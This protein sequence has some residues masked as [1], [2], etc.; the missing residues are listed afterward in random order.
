MFR[1]IVFQLHKKANNRYFVLK[2]CTMSVFAID[3]DGDDDMDIIAAA[4]IGNSVDWWENDG[5]QN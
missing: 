2:N 3:M 1:K 4:F 5:E